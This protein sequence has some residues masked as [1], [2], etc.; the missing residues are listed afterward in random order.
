M[1]KKAGFTLLEL[2]I[3][4]TV[5]TF[6]A[7]TLMQSLRNV[8][9]LITKSRNILLVNKSVTLLFNQIERDFNTAFIPSSGQIKDDKNNKDTN[10]KNKKDKK[11]ESKSKNKNKEDKDKKSKKIFFISEIDEDGGR[12]KTADRK[13]KAFKS[14][15]FVNT[16]PLQIWGQKKTRLVRVSYELIQNKEKSKKGPV[17]Y[18]L[19]R[20]ETLNIENEK[21]K[22]QEETFMGTG[23]D[24]KTKKAYNAIKKNLVAANIKGMYVEYVMPKPKKK[25]AKERD[26]GEE[27]EIL[28]SATWGKNKKNTKNIVPQYVE[29]YIT[30]WSGKSYKK[31]EEKTYSCLIPIFS[32]PTPQDTQQNKHVG[33]TKE[34]VEKAEKEQ[35]KITSKRRRGAKKPTPGG[36]QAGGA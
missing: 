6:V 20:K 7:L 10:N 29:I 1:R 16:N 2:L 8:Q 18:D 34:E 4:M 28:R 31:N 12:F 15:S 25:D 21:F 26:S 23:E 35:E 30:F 36:S 14:A 9:R 19:Y 32:Y 27:Q 5:S 24:K 11:K 22:E 17:S 13:F 33:K 3:A